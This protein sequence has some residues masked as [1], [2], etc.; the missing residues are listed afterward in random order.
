[1][2]VTLSLLRNWWSPLN[3]LSHS[4]FWGNISLNG[5]WLNNMPMIAQEFSR[6]I[7]LTV[8]NFLNI[9]NEVIN[10]NHLRSLLFL[11]NWR[12][13]RFRKFNLVLWTLIYFFDLILTFIWYFFKLIFTC[14]QGFL[15]SNEIHYDFKR[16]YFFL[17]KLPINYAITTLSSLIV[18]LVRI[19][20][21]CRTEESEPSVLLSL[22]Y[23]FNSTTGLHS[24]GIRMSTIPSSIM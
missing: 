19:L 11:I 24:T 21:L 22:Y 5:M 17:G 6:F 7:F 15:W 9:L 20:D 23:S 18:S 10:M 13:P 8:S 16:T 14:L 1:M 3:C 2:E 12:I 4:S